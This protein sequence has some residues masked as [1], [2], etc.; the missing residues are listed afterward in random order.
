MTSSL[1]QDLTCAFRQLKRAPGASAIAILSLALGIGANV[2]VFSWTQTLI[3][4]PL[5]GVENSDR[6]VVLT[7]LFRP[8]G[9]E[10]HSVSLPDML[11]L[12]Q[13]TD[14][15]AGIATH[16]QWMLRLED[17]EHQEWVWAQPVG[18][19]FFSLLGVK[20]ALGRLLDGPLADSRAEP[21]VVLSHRFWERAFGAD[22]GVIGRSFRLNRIPVT[23]VG[24]AAPGFEGAVGGLA[25]DLWLPARLC[26]R[27]DLDGPMDG[28]DSR[29]LYAIGRLQPG[30]SVRAAETVAETVSRRL[31]AAYPGTNGRASLLLRPLARAPYGAQG[32][33][34]P[35]VRIL[36]TISALVLVLILVNLTSL[37][38]AQATTRGKELAIR[39]ALGANRLRIV[40][41]LLTESVLLALLGGTVGAAVATWGV[42]LL[43]LL[44]VHTHLPVSLHLQLEW[45]SLLFAALLAVG[46]GLLLGISTAVRLSGGSCEA[47][48]RAESRSV[49]ATS[50]RHLLRSALIVA[51][52]A[53]ATLVLVGAGLCLKSFHEAQRVRR[54]FDPNRVLVA[55]LVFTAREHDAAERRAFY[56]RLVEEVRGLPSVDSV[57]LADWVPLGPKGV[58]GVGIRVDGYQP[59]PSESMA[60]SYTVTSPGHLETLRIPLLEGRDLAGSDDRESAGVV[61][62]NEATARRF[63]PGQPAVGRR[64]TAWGREFRV[65]GVTRDIKTARLSEAPVPLLMFS[66]RQVDNGTVTQILHVR[67]RED[68]KQV[69]AT[70][71]KRVAA[72]D[73]SVKLFDAMPMTLYTDLAIA[74]QRITAGL[75]FVLG[76]VALLLASLGIFGVLAYVV[77]QRT[78]ELG[79]RVALGATPGRI[80]HLVLGQGLRWV[81]LGIVAGLLL[82][83]GLSRILSGFLIGVDPTDPAI[84]A[85]VAVLFTLVG[86]LACYLPARRAVRLDPLAALRESA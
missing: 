57:S 48:L 80:L 75:L 61:V 42:E 64:L 7:T 81:G 22:P 4:H 16:S 10:S 50:G 38:L 25:F 78:N 45:R 49:G 67:S 43:R 29:W 62:V 24:V 18:G 69:M 17:P 60:L 58:P 26:S 74:P 83:T 15:F 8:S 66:Y 21:E 47:A 79:V 40:R 85:S 20:P 9:S 33:F 84:F 77:A 30:V 34:M 13:E 27:L 1:R 73:P 31:A 32:L 2:V 28:R 76:G 52:T 36:I 63:W 23:V 68:P 72:L 5:P 54:G 56:Q 12:A 70:V 71:E 11:D 53:L 3:R 19:H 41:Q 35:V 14:T 37:L 55:P 59:E 39:Q 6:L 82:A 44:P 51:E 46:C 65:V 86:A